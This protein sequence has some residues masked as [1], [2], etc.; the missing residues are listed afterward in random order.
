MTHTV[1][2]TPSIKIEVRSDGYKNGTVEFFYAFFF[3][4]KNLYYFYAVAKI[5]TRLKKGSKIFITRYP[6]PQKIFII[7]LRG[8]RKIF[9]GRGPTSGVDDRRG[10]S[11]LM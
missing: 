6:G 3:G 9:I 10:R 8:W 4:V 5:F 7:F 1:L 11:P 2:S